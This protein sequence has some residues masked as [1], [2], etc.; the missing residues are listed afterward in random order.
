MSEPIV[1]NDLKGVGAF[2]LAGGEV[3]QLAPKF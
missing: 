2:I 3:N 1:T